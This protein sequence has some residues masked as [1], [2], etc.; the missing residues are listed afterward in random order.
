MRFELRAKSHDNLP[1]PGVSVE[2]W[3]GD[4]DNGLELAGKLA[5]THPQW[6]KFWRSCEMG[7]NEAG[8][9]VVAYFVRE[10]RG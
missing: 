1:R 5:L 3:V 4:D 6:D 2:V 10:D 8:V 7:G 9:D